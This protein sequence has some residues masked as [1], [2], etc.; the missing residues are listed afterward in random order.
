M[1]PFTVILFIQRVSISTASMVFI[2]HSD[3]MIA[4]DIDTDTTVNDLLNEFYQTTSAAVADGV[5]LSHQGQELRDRAALL[6][7]LGI[8]S[9][10][11]LEF[12]PVG[13]F[14]TTS[15]ISEGGAIDDKRI[16]Y[17][18]TVEEP[19]FLEEIDRQTREALSIAGCG[20]RILYKFHYVGSTEPIKVPVFSSSPR[21]F[22][23]D[24]RC[25]HKSVVEEMRNVTDVL[26]QEFEHLKGS[27]DFAVGYVIWIEIPLDVGIL[28][29]D[30]YSMLQL[31]FLIC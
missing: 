21:N 8:C 25:V 27:C 14:K 11:V 30:F 18:I 20:E 12:K 23:Y 9:E 4:V 24:S 16:Y 29:F 1:I 31:L 5:M 3:Q 6:S 19:G 28:I 17:F 26:W 10:L 7:D 13:H 22:E 2:R 15:I